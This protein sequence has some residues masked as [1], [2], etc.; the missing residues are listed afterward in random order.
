[1]TNAQTPRNSDFICWSGIGLGC[2]Y[3]SD[4]LGDSD[5]HPELRSTGLEIL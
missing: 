5:G 3:F 4:S 2:Q 1:M